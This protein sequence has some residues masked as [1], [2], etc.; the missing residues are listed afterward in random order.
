MEKVKLWKD[1]VDRR[2]REIMKPF[3]PLSLYEAMSYYLF[4]EGKRIRPLFLLSVTDELGGNLEDA[5]L[6]GCA[7][8]MVHNY[9]LIHDDLPALDNDEER[10]GKPTCHKV[11]G[12]DLA[13]LA[14]DALLTYAFEVLSNPKAF[15]KLS[16]AQVLKVINVI[17]RKAGIEGMVS[18]QVLD[19]KGEGGN[20]NIS[21]LKT[22]ALFEACFMCGGICSD[23]ENLE[24]LEQLGRKVGLLFQITDDILDG[25]GYYETYG[26]RAKEIA[27]ELYSRIN[28]QSKELFTNGETF[29]CL[30]DKVISRIEAK[31]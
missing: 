31:K 11:F 26:E 16:E 12:E 8:E 1:E 6:I 25:D 28:S 27:L 4:Q 5:T 23:Y 15:N 10:R 13:I 20:E 3:E 21:L 19:I 30:V 2:L 14:G 9:S 18:G 29:S 7:I 24:E 17:S 22:A